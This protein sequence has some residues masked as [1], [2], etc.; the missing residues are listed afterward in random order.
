MDLRSGKGSGDGSGRRAAL[1]EMGVA[2]AV[3]AGDAG[4]YLRVL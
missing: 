3:A 4:K 2:A 1:R